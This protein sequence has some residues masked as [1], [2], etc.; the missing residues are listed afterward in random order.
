MQDFLTK[1]LK[2]LHG[3]GNLRN[4]GQPML[5]V[6]EVLQVSKMP[7]IQIFF[8]SNP[9]EIPHIQTSFCISYS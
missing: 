5:E 7:F 9:Y 6:G 4:A 2:L 1:N 3:L 8:E